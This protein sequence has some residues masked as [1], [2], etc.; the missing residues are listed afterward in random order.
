MTLERL[1][2]SCLS[3]TSIFSLKRPIFDDDDDSDD[4][5]DLKS[6]N[7]Q[8][9]GKANDESGTSNPSKRFKA[10]DAEESKSDLDLEDPELEDSILINL[11]FPDATKA[12]KSEPAPT[13]TKIIAPSFD[14][15]MEDPSEGALILEVSL[16]FSVPPF[17]EI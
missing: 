12:E 15:V 4:N 16:T 5:D 3:S 10:D 11:E 9:D 2:N 13:K 1:I 7:E 6:E 8:V 17:D 14:D